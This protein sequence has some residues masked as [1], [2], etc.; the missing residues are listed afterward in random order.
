VR[1]KIYIV[2]SICRFLE[3]QKA[4]AGDDDEVFEY[5]EDGNVIW[6]WKKVIDPLTALDHA[7]VD[8]AP[9]Q[10]NFYAEHSDISALN[11]LQ[12]EQLR[13]TLNVKTSGLNVPKPVT[14]FAHFGFDEQLM[15]VIRKSEYTQPTSIQAQVGGSL[16]LRNM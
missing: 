15:N 16:S 1:A 5:D 12:A 4:T 6:S 13:Q 2:I 11:H 7:S 14:S 10:R 8:Y 3:E 9:F